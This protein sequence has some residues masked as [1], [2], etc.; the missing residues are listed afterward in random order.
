MDTWMQG[1]IGMFIQKSVDIQ[2]DDTRQKKDEIP[3]PDDGFDTC[4]FAR[5]LLNDK[6]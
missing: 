1:F 6:G 2:Q 5:N 4:N 3:C